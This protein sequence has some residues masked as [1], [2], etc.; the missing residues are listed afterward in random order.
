[1]F[2]STLYVL[3]FILFVALF[4]IA[5]SIKILREYERAVLFTLGRFQRVKGP[6]LMLLMPF[7]Q[8]MV[9]VDLRIQVI[10]IPSQDVISRD[11][12]SMKVDA[13]LYFN[14]VN[15]ERAIIKVQNY[16]PAT[17]MLAQTTLRVG[18]GSARSRRNAFRA[19]KAQHRRAEHPGRPDRNLGDQSEQR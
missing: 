17:N 15:S 6:G 9:R 3:P 8:E 10:E 19:K 12:V 13:V 5:S 14:V 2:F 1:M 16:L 7:V 11:N 18:A 4:L